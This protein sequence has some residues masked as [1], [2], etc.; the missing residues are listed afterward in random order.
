[1]EA[2]MRRAI[3]TPPDWPP[4]D[5][6][7]TVLGAVAACSL[8]SWG[9]A[10][11]PEHLELVVIELP[12]RRSWDPGGPLSDPATELPA[13]EFE[14]ALLIVLFVCTSATEVGVVGRDLKAAPAAADA[15]EAFED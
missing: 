14:L 2:G 12:L 9:L 1:M 3:L 5:A 7:L 10:V 15:R 11:H 13:E 4:S 8:E 6:I